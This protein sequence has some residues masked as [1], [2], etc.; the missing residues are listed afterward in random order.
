MF[1][2]LSTAASKGIQRVFWLKTRGRVQEERAPAETGRA[3]V[4]GSRA[5]EGGAAGRHGHGRVLQDLE[6]SGALAAPGITSVQMT[7]LNTC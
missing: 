5:K 4:R 1:F 3:G 7:S 2:L 6:G